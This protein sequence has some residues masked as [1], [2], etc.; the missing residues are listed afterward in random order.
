MAPGGAHVRAVALHE[1]GLQNAQS[2]AIHRG[3][4]AGNYDDLD[5]GILRLFWQS[6][7]PFG[8]WAGLQPRGAP[9]RIFEAVLQCRENADRRRGLYSYLACRIGA[10]KITIRTSTV[11]ISAVISPNFVTRLP[12]YFS[13]SHIGRLQMLN[14]HQEPS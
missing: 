3:Q 1:A 11:K 12:E 5:P 4:V 14:S 7:Q 13:K 2:V 9:R 8:E 6:R 10:A